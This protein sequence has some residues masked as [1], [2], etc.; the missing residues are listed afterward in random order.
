[1]TSR[2]Q[3]EV[4]QTVILPQSR[5]ALF[6]TLGFKDGGEAAALEVLSSLSSLT[7]AV[8]SRYPKAHLTA[9]AGRLGTRHPGL[10]IETVVDP[11][12][13]ET[14]FAETQR[15]HDNNVKEFEQWCADNQD[16]C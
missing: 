13:G 11:D 14:K 12:T 9:V 7:N 3:A 5:D 4:T 15:E 8:G 2:N 1:M 16:R 10:R 6:I